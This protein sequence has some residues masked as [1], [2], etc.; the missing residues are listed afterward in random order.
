LSAFKNVIFYEKWKKASMLLLKCFWRIC[1]F[2]VC[3]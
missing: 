1:L 3:L 2:Y